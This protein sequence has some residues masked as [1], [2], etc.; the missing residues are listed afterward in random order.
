MRR[1]R[2][3][4]TNPTLAR[5]SQSPSL[6][7]D[8]RGTTLV[9][10]TV[11][12]VL[13]A[14]AGA[15][16][17]EEIIQ[18]MVNPAKCMLKQG[19]GNNWANGTPI[20]LFDCDAGSPKNRTWVWDPETGYISSPI[21]PDK[22]FHKQGGGNNWANG[23]LIHLYD[24]EAGSINNKTWDYDPNTGYVMARQNNAKCLH[25]QGGRNNW[26]NGTPI[27]LYDCSA[28]SPNNKTW[29]VSTAAA[30]G[31]MRF[32]GTGKVLIGDV[33][34]L[35]GLQVFTG[36]AWVKFDS[37]A[38]FQRVFSKV[39]TDN[40]NGFDVLTYQGRIDF[41]PMNDANVGVHTSPGTLQTDTWMHIA[42][43]YDGTKTGNLERA[44]IYL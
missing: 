43:V 17:A 30:S 20:H 15:V 22:C 34:A 44:K 2:V 26:A 37:G 19:G 29:N 31:T 14:S 5:T 35:D 6:I 18:S 32:N 1:R 13:L 25:K 11:L 3:R 8:R 21:N 10:L 9:L 42:V 16:A 4:S 33:D 23:T 38:D 12:A 27:H 7:T 24:C 36:E 41:N 28:G 39:M 40:K